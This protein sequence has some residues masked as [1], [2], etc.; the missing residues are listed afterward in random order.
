[1]YTS[2]ELV[3]LVNIGGGAAVE[4][5]DQELNKVLENLDDV[6]KKGKDERSITVTVKFK[7]GEAQGI[8]GTSIEVKSKLSGQRVHPTHIMIGRN[9][10]K[11]EARE[12]QQKQKPL[13]FTENVVPMN[14]DE[15]S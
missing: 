6:N 14:Q 1:M 15:S 10:T 3:S 8:I 12:L 5:F 11:M 13:P 9:G 4:M 7:P 2:D